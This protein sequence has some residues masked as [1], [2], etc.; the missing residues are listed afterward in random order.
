MHSIEV[1]EVELNTVT[2]KK[3][4]TDKK[5]FF[6]YDIEPKCDCN[7]EIMGEVKNDKY[8]FKCMQCGKKLKELKEI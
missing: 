4:M 7:A 1:C 8:I 2:G 5:W 6:E 3:Q